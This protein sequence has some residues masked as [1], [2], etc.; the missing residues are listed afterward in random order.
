MEKK[1]YI[2]GFDPYVNASTQ[3]S[4]TIHTVESG[5]VYNKSIPPFLPGL[6]EEMANY[7]PKEKPK[8][9]VSIDPGKNGGIVCMVN[10]QLI[11]KWIIPI[12]GDDID[13][14][15]LYGIIADLISQY[16]VT[17]ILEDVHSIFG[18]SAASNF[19]FGFVCGV[20][21]AIVVSQN[22]RLIKVQPKA[23][24]KVVWTNS[25]MQYKPKKPE[26][27]KA[28][29]DTKATSLMAAKRLFPN[30]DFRKS[31][32]AK[33]AHDGLIDAACMCYYAQ[34]LNL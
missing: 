16:R 32:R 29:I 27:K 5:V 15:T 17:L 31:E 1:Q 25:D 34:R 11:R 8:A 19:A 9:I 26:Q 33:I 20:I 28:S 18:T 3:D 7:T 23:W 6:I 14:R 2:M 12:S 22:V 10:E 24:Q 21:E 30:D 4:V 13:I